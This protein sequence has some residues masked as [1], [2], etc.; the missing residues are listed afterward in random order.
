MA[1]AD[2]GFNPAD[3]SNASVST[4][5]TLSGGLITS[6]L[7]T[8]KALGQSAYGGT[9]AAETLTLVGSIHASGGIV[10]VAASRT[11]ASG[12]SITW[13]AISLGSTSTATLSGAVN[14]TTA[15]GFNMITVPAPTITAASALTV[16]S[17]ATVTILGAPT[18]AGA[19]PATITNPYTF[20]V[21]AGAT[22]LNGTLKVGSTS[23]ATAAASPVFAVFNDGVCNTS[24]RDSTNNVEF[25]ITAGSSTVDLGS[26]TNHPVRFYSN[27]T[28]A[29]TLSTAGNASLAGTLTF[30]EAKDVTVGTTTG[31]K[32]G[33]GT[34]QKLGFWNAAPVVQPA[35]TGTTTTGFTAN[36]SANV[37]CAESTFT[38][39]TGSTTYTVSDIVKN[40]KTAGILAS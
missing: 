17:A 29:L 11:L 38:G 12:A 36:A 4:G 32:I 16:T 23:E 40:L 37:V 39:N 3:A 30:A 7:S 26:F 34:T 18:G 15:A 22:K 14:V 25:V 2:I 24:F 20:W 1:T 8:G 35:S 5:L 27:S 19:G 10:A 21:Q 33:T 6:D 13:D 9:A 31:T 28:L